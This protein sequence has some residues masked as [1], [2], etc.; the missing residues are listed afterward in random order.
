MAAVLNWQNPIKN[1][2][3]P[4]CVVMLDLKYSI[5]QNDSRDWGET[6]E[7]MGNF[8]FLFCT[9]PAER[10]SDGRKRRVDTK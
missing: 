3:A 9:A 1:S 4:F 10:K 5:S 7:L 6:Q 8:C 2:R